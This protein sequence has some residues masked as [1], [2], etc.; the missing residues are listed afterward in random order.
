MQAH[1]AVDKAKVGTLEGSLVSGTRIATRWAHGWEEGTVTAVH[2]DRKTKLHTYT[3]TYDDGET[4][5]EDLRKEDARYLDPSPSAELRGGQQGVQG[6]KK[7]LSQG[8]RDGTEVRRTRHRLP[9]AGG[10]AGAVGASAEEPGGGAPSDA[11]TTAATAD[12]GSAAAA[13]AVA[14]VA[15]AAGADAAD[16]ADT[17]DDE[18][19]Q[20]WVS[21]DDCEKWRRVVNSQSLRSARRW[22]CR[23]NVDARH[24]SCAAPQVGEQ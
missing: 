6:S 1:R 5:D 4:H 21:C 12:A 16:A 2:I 19:E 24:K 7:R 23:D 10:A 9:A 20:T 18:P 22:R 17:S 8:S 14:V 3:V 13:A 11:G 15:A